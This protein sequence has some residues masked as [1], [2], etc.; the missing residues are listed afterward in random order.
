MFSRHRQSSRAHPAHPLAAPTKAQHSSARPQA[1]AGESA[2][3]LGRLWLPTGTC[4]RHL[5]LPCECRRAS[6]FCRQSPV[7]LRPRA[8]P[9]QRRLEAGAHPQASA[10]R[11]QPLLEAP[12]GR[13]HEAEEEG[14]R[15]RRAAL[16]L[17]VEL[18]GQEEGVVLELHELHALAA[19]IL[20][21]EG[22]ALSL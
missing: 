2:D 9:S 18:A 5:S 3:S 8:P 7:G 10:V 6:K 21:D 17:R 4:C 12:L 20:A 14:A 16:E 19:I 11:D 1:K 22:Q 13:E 15:L